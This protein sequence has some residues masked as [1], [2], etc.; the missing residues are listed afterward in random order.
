MTTADVS[1]HLS[2]FAYSKYLGKVKRAGVCVC[3]CVRV[4]VCVCVCVCVSG[5]A[6]T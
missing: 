3:V 1:L 6:G 4:R 5:L 2:L